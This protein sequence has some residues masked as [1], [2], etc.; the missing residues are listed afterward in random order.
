MNRK[1]WLS[2]RAMFGA[3]VLITDIKTDAPA[4]SCGARAGCCH[5]ACAGYAVS[6]AHSAVCRSTAIAAR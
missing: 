2:I 5:C 3:Q 1:R 6:D 4:R